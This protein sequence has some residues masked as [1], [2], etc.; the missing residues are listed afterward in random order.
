[1]VGDGLGT[2]ALLGCGLL[3]VL[4]AHPGHLGGRHGTG[5]A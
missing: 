4:L 3:Q 5:L 1:M 2:G